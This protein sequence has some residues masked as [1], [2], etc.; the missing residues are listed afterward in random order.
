MCLGLVFLCFEE[1][2]KTYQ[3]IKIRCVDTSRIN[4]KQFYKLLCF[5]VFVMVSL[6]SIIFESS[7]PHPSPTWL[8]GDSGCA[9]H[10]ITPIFKHLYL[11]AQTELWGRP[12][13][14]SCSRGPW[15]M[16]PHVQSS[17]GRR[18]GHLSVLLSISYLFPNLSNPVYPPDEML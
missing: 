12:Q 18:R 7:Y 6:F 17:L 16:I 14:G 11:R 15:G 9:D 10:L 5:C 3:N 13:H 4:I 1:N 8:T 2:L